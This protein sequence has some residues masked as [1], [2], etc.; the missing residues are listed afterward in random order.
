MIFFLENNVPYAK[1][2]VIK[3]FYIQIVH[4][5]NLQHSSSILY[6]GE[7]LEKLPRLIIFLKKTKHFK[8]L[9]LSVFISASFFIFTLPLFYPFNL[10]CTKVQVWNY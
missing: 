2:I 4:F 6:F 7:Y 5:R 1:I 9:F 10:E 3:L 8:I